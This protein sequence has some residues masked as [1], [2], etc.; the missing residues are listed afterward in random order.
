MVELSV[1]EATQVHYNNQVIIVDGCTNG[2]DDTDIFVRPEE[3]YKIYREEL[4][5]K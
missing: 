3:G 1:E 4:E 2:P 5:N